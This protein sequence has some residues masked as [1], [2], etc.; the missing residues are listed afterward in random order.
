MTVVV[1]VGGAGGPIVSVTS[2]MIGVLEVES[3]QLRAGDVGRCD[4]LDAA[5]P[6][7]VSSTSPWRK[8]VL[9]CRECPKLGTDEAADSDY[10]GAPSK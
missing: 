3:N 5:P 9:V 8:E 4:P 7:T 6:V 2:M 1:I 10:K